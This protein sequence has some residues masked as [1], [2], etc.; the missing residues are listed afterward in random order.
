MPEISSE[1]RDLWPFRLLD[2]LSCM[3]A[4]ELEQRDGPELMVR[5]WVVQGP[6]KAEIH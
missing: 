5:L 6:Q 2:V 1:Q 3:N 4:M